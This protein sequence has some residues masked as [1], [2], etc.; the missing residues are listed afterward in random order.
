MLLGLNPTAFYLQITQRYTDFDIWNWNSSLP[1]ILAAF[2]DANVLRFGEEP[3]C[4]LAAFAANTPCLH[5]AGR[6]AQIA[7]D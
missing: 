4:F 5:P 2:C 3:E 7:H 1:I 6:H